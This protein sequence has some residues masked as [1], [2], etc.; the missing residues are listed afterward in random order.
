MTKFILRIT[1]L[2]LLTCFTALA[3]KAQVGYDY[4]QYDVGASV[5]FN[6]YYGDV[7]TS[8]SSNSFN[9]NFDYNQSAFINYILEIQVGKVMGGDSTKDLLGRQFSADYTSYAFRIQLQAG[10]LIDYSQSKVLNAFKNLYVG[11]GIGIIYSNIKEINRY[12]LQLP[13]FYTPGENK[14]NQLFF[15]ARIGYELKI[16]N[17][18]KRPDFKVD[19]GYQYNFIFGDNFDG[20]KAG[21][22]N[23]AY[24]QF[25][26]G[27]K[28]SIGGVT[29]YRKDIQY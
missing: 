16:Y 9:L 2:T 20:F 8:Q 14:A 7:V 1:L 3:S 21:A 27:V 24:G 11:G 10:E 28:F 26:I 17:K 18:Y 23:D 5:G 4:S 13:G 25:T 22:H 15:P 29:S 6:S 12:S 19:V